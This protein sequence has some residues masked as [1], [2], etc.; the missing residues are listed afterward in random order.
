M[1]APTLT[2]GVFSINFVRNE[3]LPVRTRRIILYAAL[4]YLAVNI[5]WAVGLS[6]KAVSASVKTLSLERQLGKIALSAPSQRTAKP[7]MESLHEQALQD[8][9]QVNSLADFMKRRFLAAG[10]LDALGQTLPARTWITEI[11]GSREARTLT[12]QAM[13]FVDSGK[14]YELPTKAWIA[15]L[16]ADPRFGRG[17]KQLELGNSFQKTQGTAELFSFELLAE[18]AKGGD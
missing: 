7:E 13:Y 11:S 17:L 3:F 18:W 4:G 14:P 16:K 9:H 1:N 15:A 8:L 10:K 12:L 2:R 6:G 5:L